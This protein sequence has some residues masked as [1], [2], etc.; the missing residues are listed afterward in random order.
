MINREEKKTILAVIENAMNR[1]IALAD[2]AESY[3]E[4]Q[5]QWGQ[6]DG[7][8]NASILIAGRPEH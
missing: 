8:L 2:D 7:L 3:E 4:K 5:Y 6:A 1:C